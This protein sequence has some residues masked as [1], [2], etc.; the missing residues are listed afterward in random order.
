MRVSSTYH[1]ILSSCFGV[2]KELGNIIHSTY[3]SIG[4]V[5][6]YIVYLVMDN[7]GVN[8]ENEA[9]LDYIHYLV[10]N[11]NIVVH[12]QLPW[13][14][15]TNILFIGSCMTVQST[16]KMCHHLNIKQK[17]TLFRFINNT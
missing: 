12:Y 13:Y 11:Y 1:V 8:K 15:K 9:V 4:L 16:A 10:T 5:D 14:P 17:Y 2:I 6:K 7:E 3:L